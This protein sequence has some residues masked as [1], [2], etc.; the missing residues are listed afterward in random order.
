MMKARDG[1]GLPAIIDYAVLHASTLRCGAC[2]RICRLRC[3]LGILLLVG[4]V[5]WW[6]R[7]L[8]RETS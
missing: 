1:N 4:A 5:V 3:I 8:T 6:D 2:C 7:A